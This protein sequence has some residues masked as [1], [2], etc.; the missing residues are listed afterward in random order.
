MDVESSIAERADL[1][2]RVELF[3]GLSRLALAK[4]AAHLVPVALANGEE[5]F[6]Q[7]DPGD[8]FYLIARG[9][10]GV[11][12]TDGGDGGENR[13]ATLRAG[14]PVGEMALLTS[15]PR[16]ATIRAESDGELLRLDRTRFL[17][18]VRQEPDVLL[19]IAATVT[20][21]LQNTLAGVSAPAAE[22][23][24]ES[25]KPSAEKAAAPASGKK[26]T[27]RLPSRAATGALLAAVILV[28]GCFIAPPEGLSLSGWRALILLVAAV[29]VLATEAL[30]EGVLALLL[31]GAW[32]IGGVARPEIAL[33]G[34]ASTS[35]VLVVSVLAVGAAIAASGVLYRLALWIVAHTKGGFVGQV[36]ALSVAGVVMGPAVPNA[37][38]RVTIVAPALKELVEALGYAPR[39][40]AAVGLSMATLI[41]FG[42]MVGTFLTSST[43][44]VLVFAVLPPESRRGLTWLTWAYYAAPANAILFI[45]IVAAILML[46]RSSAAAH[47]AER[48]SALDLQRALLG[49][50]TRRERIALAVGA[51]LVIGFATEPLHGVNAAW[52]SVLALAVLAATGV[53][54]AA[55]LRDVNWSFALL[56]GMLVGISDVFSSTRVDQ[57]VAR[58][59]AANVGG[60]TTDRALFILVLTLFCF[61]VSL[62]LR[63]QA[64]AP[65]V[66]IALAPAASAAGIHPFV[67][68]FVAL[69]ACNTFFLPYQS[70]TYLALYHG[71][72]GE[73][74][75]HRQARPAAFAYALFCLIALVGS[76]FFWKLMGLL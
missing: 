46:Y 45:G 26:P 49:R 13:V 28:S 5:L 8:A 75:S 65:L 18:L 2:A 34:F 64:A 7:G 69:I 48:R 73:L 50:A 53:L 10:V 32:V 31:S 9:E 63:W 76:V 39:S 12:V 6:R 68:G 58:T 4:L 1:L 22:E 16:S 44:A 17:R 55:T 72:G 33:K 19:A 59:M 43:T 38:G 24:V 51:G 20:R 56:F 37:T 29:P 3:A 52:V 14:A 35:W 62:V 70:T 71:T 15:S 60:L 61:I 47:D 57:W 36:A 54:N 27:R 42:Q 21:R 40:A 25:V 11:Y 67:V 41:G 66:T 23:S 74:F 30:P